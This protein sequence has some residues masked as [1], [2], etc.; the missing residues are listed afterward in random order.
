MQDKEEEQVVLVL[1][2]Q[3]EE[4]VVVQGARQVVLWCQGHRMPSRLCHRLLS[5]LTIDR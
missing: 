3:E 1:V 4:L 2:P 5:A